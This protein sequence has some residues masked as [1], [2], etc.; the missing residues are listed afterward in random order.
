M[1]LM[2]KPKNNKETKP[3]AIAILIVVAVYVI[4][5]NLETIINNLKIIL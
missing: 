1:L 3:L 2:M 4:F 5:S